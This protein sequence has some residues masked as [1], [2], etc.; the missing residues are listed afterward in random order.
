MRD[1]LD[2]VRQGVRSV[3]IPDF[4]SVMRPLL[5]VVADGHE[6]RARDYVEALAQEFGLSPEERRQL[7]ASGRQELFVNRVAW[8]ATHLAKAELLARPGRGIIQI[9]DR[10]R[11]AL[12]SNPVRVDMAYLTRF[13]EYEAFR[14]R[15]PLNGAVEPTLTAASGQE[16]EPITSTPPSIPLLPDPPAIAEQTPAELLETSYQRLRQT[17]ADD[18]LERIRSASPR[19]LE[20]LVVDLLVTMGYGGSRA[21]AGQAVGGSGDDGVDGII[22]EDRLGL[23]FVYVQAKRWDQPVGRPLVQAFAGSLEGQRARKG[24]FNTTSTFTRDAR[25]YV[26]RIEKRIVLVDGEQLAQL[27]IDHGVGVADVTTYRVKRVDADYFG[28]E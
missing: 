25:D 9:T 26:T 15:P 2:P 8:A 7:I 27:M 19:F 4:Q 22:K 12:R 11:E 10:G 13:P 5:R 21:D 14:R 1:G 6:H 16:A 3:T 28:E 24:V 17:L 18:L 23:D 20:Q